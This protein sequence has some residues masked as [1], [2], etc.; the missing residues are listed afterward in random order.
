VEK[1]LNDEKGRRDLIFSQFFEEKNATR[2]KKP[3]L[4]KKCSKLNMSAKQIATKTL[5]LSE[6]I[7]LE[8]DRRKIL[9]LLNVSETLSVC[10]FFFLR[11]SKDV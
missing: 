8:H 2:W 3:N 6:K 5:K 9:Y 4:S 10:R 1:A 11:V 7:K